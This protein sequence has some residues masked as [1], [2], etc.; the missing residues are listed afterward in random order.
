ME[1]NG[2]AHIQITVSDYSKCYPF[3]RK[4]FEFLEMKLVFDTEELIYG[5]GSRTGILVRGAN[6]AYQ[7]EVFEQWRIGLHHFCFRARSREDIDG[8]YTF[9]SENGATI[10]HPPEDAAWA[11]GYYSVLFEDPD[12]IRIE[13][14]HV[15][16]R[17]K[18]DPHS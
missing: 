3:Y 16:G 13:A 2:I 4:L 8:L 15:P 7:N 5:V 1:M 18:L 12:G 10:V 17:G 11:P 14:N 6:E 9:L